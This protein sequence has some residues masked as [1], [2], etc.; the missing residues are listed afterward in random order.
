MSKE[1]FIIEKE[2][3]N[4]LRR[5][6]DEYNLKIKSVCNYNDS[7]NIQIENYFIDSENI[8]DVMDN[9]IDE[10]NDILVDNELK[11]MLSLI[12]V[13]IDIFYNLD[14]TKWAWYN[15]EKILE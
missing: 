6:V 5:L 14:S 15:N 2:N 7:D 13:K 10:L 11:K 4:K 12:G 9:I 8:D 1:Y 3:I